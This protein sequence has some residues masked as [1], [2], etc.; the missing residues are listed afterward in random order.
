MAVEGDTLVVREAHVMS[1]GPGAYGIAE[2]RV[3]GRMLAR[4]FGT[5][6]IIVYGSERTS[7]ARRGH[8]PKPIVIEAG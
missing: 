6:R 8:V 5:R 7:G 2:L 3:F 1:T 4:Y